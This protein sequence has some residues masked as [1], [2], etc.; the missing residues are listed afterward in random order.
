MKNSKKLIIGIDAS[1]NRSGGAKAHLIGI[2][3]NC[4][5]E[6]YNIK[7]IHVWAFQSLLDQIPSY[8]WLVKHNPAALEKS[9]IHQ[10]WW[11]ISSL[12]DEARLS[13]CEILFATDA[14]TLCCFE[15]MIVL[16][17]D[18]LSYEPGV[19]SLFGYGFSRF[20]LLGILALQNLAFRRASGVIFLTRY[21]GKLI[22]RSC[23]VLPNVAYIPH[24]VDTEF[25]N[26]QVQGW[27]TAEER[28]INCI[29]VSN[30]EMYKYQWIVVKAIAKLRAR[31]HNLMLT[32]IGG[33][34]GLA[35]QLINKS[36]VACDPCGLFVRQFDFLPKQE[37]AKYLGKADLFI[38][39]SG[40][41][42]FGITLLEGMTVGLP[43][44]CSNKSSLPET[45]QNGG[46]YFD[47][48][49]VNSVVEAVE[50]IVKS[51]NLRLAISREAKALSQNFNWEYCA[52]E[53]FKFIVD[54]CMKVR[55]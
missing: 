54:T 6:K 48:G 50:Q 9:L 52:D 47:P 55:N 51:A 45:L 7:E 12:A 40:C 1:R 35:Q 4:N 3:S 24:G 34:E 16:S 41:E 8:P 5:P 29:Y 49:D 21:A 33:G 43:I 42:A 53:T 17:Q 19:M 28:P 23:G 22:Q 14:S 2:L 31:G 20:R 36:I 44:A 38:F 37:L 15:P 26:I 18:L 13:G 27:P 32:L 25:K 30:A 11:Q 46:V 39:A 10:L